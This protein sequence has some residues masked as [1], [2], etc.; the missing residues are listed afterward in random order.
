M[1][2]HLVFLTM[3]AIFHNSFWVLFLPTD[4]FQK[5][6]CIGGNNNYSDSSSFVC[7]WE[8]NLTLNI[9]HIFQHGQGIC[10]F[11]EA[12]RNRGRPWEQR[13]KTAWAWHVPASWLAWPRISENSVC[14][15]VCLLV[16]VFVF[17]FVSLNHNF[18]QRYYRHSPFF[19]TGWWAI[20]A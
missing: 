6:V 7:P 16:C 3:F 10:M 19:N 17:F 9:L 1:I 20:S 18:R 2:L 13:C 12:W 15:F 4:G 11:P 14:S 8:Y 5:G